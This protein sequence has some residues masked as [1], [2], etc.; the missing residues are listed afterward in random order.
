[1]RLILLLLLSI[2]LV[3][4]GELPIN[5][6][7]TAENWT[8]QTNQPEPLDYYQDSEG[9]VSVIIFWATW[10]PYCA[11]LMPH[12]E[13]IYRKYRSKGVKFYAV[14]IYEDGKIDPI[15]YFENRKFTYTMLQN[16][17]EVA[18]QYGVKGTPGVYVVDKDKKVVY[19][20]PAGVNDVM[21]K[22]NV[23]LRIKQTLA[24]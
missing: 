18:K 20:R 17:D 1:M 13:V 23:D 5:I 2:S 10:C 4:A 15:E 6:G 24:K 7:G 8:L 12:M 16:G 19:K 11:T 9:K 14:D 22:Q 21:V 3:Q